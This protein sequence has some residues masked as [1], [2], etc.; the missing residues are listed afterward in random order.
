MTDL[1]IKVDKDK[2]DRLM[3]A[4]DRAES[5]GYMPDTMAEEWSAFEW[6]ALESRVLAEKSQVDS[7]ERALQMAVNA[8]HYSHDLDEGIRKVRELL[9]DAHQAPQSQG[10][11]AAASEDMFKRIPEGWRFYTSDFSV[12]GSPGSVTLKRNRAGEKWWL[13]LTDEQ[14]ETTSLY[15]FGRGMTIEKAIDAAAADIA[16][17]KK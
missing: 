5:K 9:A 6:E 14:R 11:K 15:Q 1:I 13:G 12:D 3:S 10:E 4:L 8:L 16:G 7:G 17:E 2:F